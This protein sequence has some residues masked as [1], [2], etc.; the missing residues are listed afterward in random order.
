MTGRCRASAI[1][2]IPTAI[3]GPTALLAAIDNA[4][5]T[6]RSLRDAAI[7]AT[8]AQPNIDFALAVLT[9][10]LGLPRDAPFHLFAL[11]RS[12]GWAAHAVEQ[13]AATA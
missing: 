4:D 6:L 10:S 5:E 1:R 8:G 11:G 13:I 12:V 3:R 2:S 7:A 9:R